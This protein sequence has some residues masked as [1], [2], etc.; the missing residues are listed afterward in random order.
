M[1]GIAEHGASL[2]F[3]DFPQRFDSYRGHCGDTMGF[4]VAMSMPRL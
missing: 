4:D 3:E 1:K 2:R